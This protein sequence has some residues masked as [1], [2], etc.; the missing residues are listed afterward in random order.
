MDDQRIDNAVRDFLGDRASASKLR[1]Y[2]E[3]L[4]GRLR[5][6]RAD[7]ARDPETRE[8]LRLKIDRLQTQIEALAE[9]EAITSFVEDTVRSS[10]ADMGAI[11]P[12]SPPFDATLPPWA[13][14]D[15]DD[16]PEP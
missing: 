8:L 5:T 3:A 15:I 10:A 14:M 2:R 7:A 12:G 4:E 6:L 1:Q 16:E 11:M 9:E 13:S